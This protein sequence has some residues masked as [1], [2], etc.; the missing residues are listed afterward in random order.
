MIIPSFRSGRSHFS[1][2]SSFLMTLF[3][4]DHA[5]HNH[6]HVLSE[7]SEWLRLCKSQSNDF[8]DSEETFTFTHRSLSQGGTGFAPM[9]FICS[10]D[11]EWCCSGCSQDCCAAIQWDWLPEC[12]ETGEGLVAALIRSVQHCKVVLVF[13]VR[14][15]FGS[16]L[17]NLFVLVWLTRRR[18]KSNSWTGHIVT[19]CSRV[20]Q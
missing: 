18:S 1:Q 5:L 2:Q 20:G 3:S 11:L 4:S 6:T 10:L 14:H 7:T 13:T 17:A 8:S 16:R 12:S 15:G 19:Y 9:R